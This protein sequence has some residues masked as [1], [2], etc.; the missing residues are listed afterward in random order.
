M[1]TEGVLPMSIETSELS[2][3]AEIRKATP[4]Q[5]AEP[6]MA[7]QGREGTTF[8]GACKLSKQICVPRC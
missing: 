1:A 5:E 2:T 3:M 4:E 7:P 6:F 8:Y